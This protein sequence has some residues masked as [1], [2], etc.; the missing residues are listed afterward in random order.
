MHAA[1]HRVRCSTA[2]DAGNGWI[3]VDHGN[4]DMMTMTATCTADQSTEAVNVPWVAIG[5]L[6]GVE[7][8]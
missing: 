4:W 1:W 7:A 6:R 3:R 8:K 5:L 2:G